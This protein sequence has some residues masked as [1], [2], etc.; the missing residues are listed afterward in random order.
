[1]RSCLYKGSRLLIYKGSEQTSLYVRGVQT[2]LYAR[3]EHIIM[4]HSKGADDVR[5][6]PIK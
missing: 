2:S 6:R 5:P 1:M 4:R 3:G